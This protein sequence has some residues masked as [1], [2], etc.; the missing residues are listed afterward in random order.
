MEVKNKYQY[1]QVGIDISNTVRTTLGPKGMNKMV[2]KDGGP[3]LTNDG[4]TIINAIKFENPIG[5]IFKKLATNQEQYIGDG[6]TTAVILGGQLLEKALELLNKK[7]HPTTIING[8]DI[9]RMETIN[10]LQKMKMSV[11]LEPI[12]KTCFGSKISS[13]MTN[14]L[15]EI[16]SKV[17]VKN[18]RMTKVE[19]SDPLL[20]EMIDGVRIEGYTINDRMPKSEVGK[21][22][23]LDLM[24][25]SDS[26]KVSLSTT[27]EL[28]KY[29]ENSREQKRAI[30]R[31]LKEL[32]VKCVF[33]TDTNAMIEAFLTEANIMSVVA[34]QKRV[35][36]NICKACNAM[37]IGDQTTDYERYLGY[38][39]VVYDQDKQSITVLSEK[40]QIKTLVLHGSTTQTLEETERAV[41]D[42]I[43][44]LRLDH[45][46][47]VGAGATEI[48]LA[49]HLRE[50]SKKI[51]GKEQIAIEKYAEA[52]ESIPLII[53]EN[54]GHDSMEV[55]TLLKNQ[56]SNGNRVLGVDPI[57]VISDANER[58][59]YE[60]VSLKT[61]AISSAT[62][63]ANL[64]LKLDDIYQG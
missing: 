15:T 42:V 22:A 6:T 13:S 43:R 40:S 37:V 64:I 29:N 8:Y 39:S 11:E 25:N 21:I 23:V 57:R 2:I 46:V 19:N 18:L 61:H 55:L 53:A 28:N 41:D 48:E 52:L 58:K 44:L 32:D 7:V 1:I 60:P 56:H 10:F 16:L 5:E 20:T 33:I 49:L 51:G 54:C 35:L 30:I 63:V 50:Y 24:T 12:I 62:E 36:D 3:I 27:E 59:I 9:A 47:V 34:Y 31:K 45:D 38:G 14:R 17:D 26:A 4:A